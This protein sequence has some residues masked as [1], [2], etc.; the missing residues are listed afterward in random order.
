MRR[1][2]EDRSK[3]RR[4]MNVIMRGESGEA[5]KAHGGGGS[6]SRKTPRG[7]PARREPSK[8]GRQL[9]LLTALTVGLLPST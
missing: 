1:R 9:A 5:R 2:S 4:V 6:L 3:G 7:Q 8:A